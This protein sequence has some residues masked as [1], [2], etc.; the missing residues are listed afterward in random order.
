MKDNNFKEGQVF[1]KVYPPEAAVWCNNN[2][3]HIE[4]NKD[5]KFVIVKNVV[6]EPTKQS[7]LVSKELQYGMNRWQR[8]GILAEGSLY[9][10]YTKAKAQEL[11]DLAQEL[12]DEA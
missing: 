3:H 6:Y 7:I 5:G 8:E 9:S 12:R 1:D 10:D 2:N 11:E 4:L